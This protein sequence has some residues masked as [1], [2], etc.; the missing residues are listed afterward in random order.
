M[1]V[2]YNEGWGQWDTARITKMVKDLDPTRLVN[3]ASGWTD[4]GVGDVN[5]IH[6]YPGPAAPEPEEDR[7]GV[8]GEFGGLGL[9]LRGH[10]WQ[11][12][13]NWGYR[14]FTNAASLTSAYIDLM[15]NLFPLI[16]TKGLSA[17][18]YTQTT[19]VEVEVNGLLTYD[20]AIVKMPADV[21]RSANFGNFPPRPR[22]IEVVPTAQT[23]RPAWRYTTQSPGEGWQNPAFN[24]ESWK[25]GTAGFGTRGTPGTIVRT[26][27]S[28]SEIWLRRNFDLPKATNGSLR[29]YMHHDEDAEVYINGVAA[30]KVTGY[31]SDYGQVEISPEA[32]ASLKETGNLMAVYCRQTSGGQY[33]DVGVVRI[34]PPKAEAKSK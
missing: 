8:L 23:E 5:D 19:D 14:S 3:N 32:T 21:V 9:P 11:S 26:E 18:V 33:I 15:A 6:R 20:R 7:A 24:A 25:L 16:V 31:T 13:K 29:L 27:W 2:P 34:E 22:I 12:E 10:T 28:T 17:A 30:A 1:W 4:R